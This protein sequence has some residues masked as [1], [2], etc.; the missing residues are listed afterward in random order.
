MV[1]TDIEQEKGR[2]RETERDRQTDIEITLWCLQHYFLMSETLIWSF[3]M[4][5]D[6]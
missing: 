6:V 4:L 5:Y 3:H 2:E 1:I